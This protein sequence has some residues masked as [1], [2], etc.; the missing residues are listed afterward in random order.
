MAGP[1]PSA[2]PCTAPP[3]GSWKA[4][5]GSREG[6]SRLYFLH[7]GNEMIRRRRQVPAG[8]VVE[9]WPDLA[10]GG[11]PFWGGEDS[12]A[13]LDAAGAQPM[14]AQLALPA[15]AGPIFYG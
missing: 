11:A 14:A 3:A 12:K 13:L 6:M 10:V 1:G 7:D 5:C 9:A 4:S 8:S 15:E 2:S